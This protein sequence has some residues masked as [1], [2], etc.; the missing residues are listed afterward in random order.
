MKTF[1]ITTSALACLMAA[2]L[3]AQAATTPAQPS[4]S[5][6]PSMGSEAPKP[7]KHATVR[8][9][10]AKHHT[11]RHHTAMNKNKNANP[12]STGSTR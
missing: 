9:H 11:P 5:S 10:T 6:Q 4:Q 7:Q 3:A 12:T 8:H 2:P 1:L